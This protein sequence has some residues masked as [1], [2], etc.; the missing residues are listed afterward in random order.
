MRRGA[1]SLTALIFL[2]L[3]AL[4]VTGPALGSVTTELKGR[5]TD[6]LGHPL[7][8]ATIAVRNPALAVGEP[9]A[10]SDKDG[11]FKIP[12]LPPGP[13]YRVKVQL[14]TYGVVEFTDIELVAGKTYTLDVVM[15]PASEMREVVRVEGHG[16]LVDTESVVTSTTFSSE[17]ISGLPVLGRDYQDVLSL[18]PGVTD[19]NGTGNPNIHGAR[20][21][22]VLTL[23][24]G[25][26]TTDPFTGYYGQQLN[27]ESIEQIEVITSGATAEFGRAQGGFA[28]I[29]TK[30]GG[31]DFKGDFKFFVRSDR[32]DGDGA[33]IDPPELRAGLGEVEGTRELSFTDYYPFL[34][35]S[36]PIMQDKLWYYL[37]SEFIQVETPINAVS[38]AFITRTRG[39]RQL[40]KLTWQITDTQKLAFAI[41]ADRTKDENQGL[42][43]LTAVEAGFAYE[44]GGP[45]FTLKETAVFSPNHLLES[46]V[47]WFDQSF[48][49]EPTLNPDTNGNGVLFIDN[50]PELG[51]NGDGFYQAR[52]RDPG[53]DFD[54]DHAFDL[55]EDFNH[56]GRLDIFYGEDRDGD[57]RLTPNGGCEGTANEDVNCNGLLD[58]EF[59]LNE[60]GVVDADEDRGLTDLPGT[61]GNG[62]FDSEDVNQNNLL[63]TVGDSGATSFPFWNDR[64]GDRTPESGEY[65]A[66]LFP[67]RDYS[68]DLRVS[69][70][71]G[72]NP[73]EYSDSRTRLSLREDFSVFVDAAGGSH[74]LKMGF[75]YERE[76]FERETT[77][78]PILDFR[79]GMGRSID[80]TVQLGGTVTA[81]LATIPTIQNTATGNNY[82][83]YLQDTYKPLSNLTLGL[84]VRVDIEDLSSFGHSTF[85][86]VA[87]RANYNALMTLT[88]V[89]FSSNTPLS[90]NNINDL[91]IQVS[92]P[93][94]NGATQGGELHIAQLNS[95]LKQAAPRRFTRHEHDVA[96][97]AAYLAQVL[98]G[99][100][101]VNDLLASGFNP[102]RDEEVS[103]Q[104]TNVSPRLSLSW[105][106]WADGKSKGF[107]SWSRFYDKLF[108]NTMILEEGPDTVTR[109]YSFDANG[110]DFFG[111]PNNQV[112]KP[113][114][115]A[116]PTAYQI[117]RQISTPYTD[118]FT[119]GFERELAPELSLSITFIHRNYHNQLQDVDANHTT[120][121]DPLTGRLADDFGRESQPGG[122]GDEG[123]GVSARE[124]DG[125]PDL[126]VQNVFFNRVFR[127]GNYNEQTYRGLELEMV[128]RLSRKWQLNG[129]YTYSRSQGDAESFLS[130]NGDD[131]SLTEYESG[132]LNYD[133]T[134]VVKLNAT[135]YLPADWQIGGTAQWAS[136]LPFSMIQDFD[137]QDNVGYIQSRKRFGYV[138]PTGH[139]VREDRNS[140]RNE[141]AYVLNARARKSFV[142][143]KASAGAFFEVYNI[144]N[145]DDLR[146]YTINPSQYALQSNAVR[147]F[148]RRFQ[149]GLQIDF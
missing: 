95:A 28:N 47:S 64:N 83:F 122:F 131:P 54:R 72:P 120:R 4:L 76:G 147:N 73:Y 39:Y 134:H 133:Q 87:E 141:S 29:I 20:D 25:I 16:D 11:N 57:G 123:S 49:R 82:G 58:R 90:F 144:L 35:L 140:H 19:V 97:Q 2:F 62:Q 18:A 92:D 91:G 135:A 149:F 23:V 80:N 36:G 9:G 79:L 40:A 26:N 116:P 145:S 96:I 105:D 69:T 121:I 53:E 15:S 30:S 103:I 93:L 139:F 110:V 32:L 137:A 130:E 94:Y 143:G 38:Q 17:F 126:Y 63:D 109:Y 61:A 115:A 41:T 48:S 132:Y 42:D 77:L 136:G 101:D 21:T 84:G 6:R 70:R 71:T 104:N 37:A 75:L 119:M 81:H 51:G 65:Q 129:S 78:R 127:L 107:A 112:G 148:G 12:Q 14:S 3:V 146:V 128:R 138:D 111:R 13:G 86:P 117:D 22:D 44:R 124:P 125:E 59:D 142:M 85:D 113:R 34:S 46:S 56:N 27:I 45:V 60:N 108:L 88:D 102:R 106:P 100:V 114:S 67:D 52:E 43:S 66:P 8:G 5:V 50:R 89:E 98:G 55:Y 118:E 1:G 99:G 31:N 33:G 74:D 10:V 24:D 7:P 68:R